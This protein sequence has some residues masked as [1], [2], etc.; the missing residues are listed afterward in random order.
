MAEASPQL[1]YDDIGN[2][3]SMSR[4]ENNSSTS[5]PLRYIDPNFSLTIEDIKHLRDDDL[6]DRIH[7]KKLHLV[8]DLDHTLIHSVP[9]SK[10][11][12][13]KK[14]VLK[15]MHGFHVTSD[16]FLVKLRPGVQEFLEQAKTMFDLSIYTMG[17]RGYANKMAD[18]LMSKVHYSSRF[19]WVI[20]REDCLN[21]LQKGDIVLSH[22]NVVLIVDDK[23]EIWA[24]S[25]KKNIIEIGKYRCY[26]KQAKDDKELARVLRILREVHNVFYES[27]FESLNGEEKYRARDVR[28]ILERVQNKEEDLC[29]DDCSESKEK[30]GESQTEK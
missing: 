6:V 20:G 26:E 19:T 22:E 25:C 18:L 30:L 21:E 24:E 1:Q 8:L 4:H 3:T 14:E 16:D 13:E 12:S 17:S 2:D 29:L 10:T 15:A 27:D 11:L 28:Q 7:R 9:L 5:I 23:K